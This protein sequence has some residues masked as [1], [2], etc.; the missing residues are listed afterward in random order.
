MRNKKLNNK[1]STLVS[2]I[3]LAMLIVIVVG[4]TLSIIVTNH[5]RSITEHS[6]KQAY[7]IALSVAETI[8]SEFEW[9][10]SKEFIPAVG[11]D[12]VINQIDLP[13]SMS[14]SAS[15]VI[16]A[17]EDDAEIVAIQV[18]ATYNKVTEKLQLTIFKDKDNWKKISYSQIGED[19]SYEDE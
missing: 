15:A 17:N 16:K 9:G 12:I 5:R 11:K 14:G 10:D 4:T 1:G 6:R 7:L 13:E 18:K 8:A 19:I 2:V 3:V